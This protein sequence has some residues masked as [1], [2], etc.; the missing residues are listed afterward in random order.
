MEACDGRGAGLF[1]NKGGFSAWTNPSSRYCLFSGMPGLEGAWL[2]GI[3][4]LL[5]TS[6]LCGFVP[7]TSLVV[8]TY[9]KE[10]RGK[11]Q[12]EAGAVVVLKRPACWLK[13]A[14]GQLWC[15]LRE[16]FAPLTH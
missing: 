15:D 4:H 9:M 7:L 2:L 13:P 14:P 6:A 5:P 8:P 3:R 12:G 1:R 10:A 11:A 16:P